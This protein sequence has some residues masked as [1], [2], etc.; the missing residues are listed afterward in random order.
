LL[1]GADAMTFLAS[2][3]LSARRSEDA[4]PLQFA[5]LARFRLNLLAKSLPGLAD[6]AQPVSLFQR[7]SALCHRLALCDPR[8]T[9]GYGNSFVC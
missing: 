4:A 7:R 3:L 1:G 5:H 2:D 6:A 8:R 9:L